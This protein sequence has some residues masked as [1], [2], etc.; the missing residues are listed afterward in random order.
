MAECSFSILLH[1]ASPKVSCCTSCGV[2]ATPIVGKVVPEIKFAVR[3]GSQGSYMEQ[4]M[5]KR[6]HQ[7]QH[8]FSRAFQTSSSPHVAQL[9][10]V[11]DG[12]S[13]EDE[14]VD[15][16][17][18]PA[19]SIYNVFYTNEDRGGAGLEPFT[20]GDALLDG[21]LLSKV[22]IEELQELTVAPAGGDQDAQENGR[23]SASLPRDKSKTKEEI[24]HIGKEELRGPSAGL[25]TMKDER[26]HSREGKKDILP[27]QSEGS[28]V[29][30]KA[31]TVARSKAR[32][33]KGKKKAPKTAQRQTTATP[34]VKMQVTSTVP[35]IKESLK[36]AWSST[37]HPI[38]HDL[39]SF[40]SSSDNH[41]KAGTRE[42]PVTREPDSGQS[43]PVAMLL[44]VTP[45]TTWI[46]GRSI[47]DDHSSDNQ[48]QATS[49][50]LHISRSDLP[51]PSTP[52]FATNLDHASTDD[53]GDETNSSLSPY[54]T[55]DEVE[56]AREWAA[57]DGSA[58]DEL[59]Q[60]LSSATARDSDTELEEDVGRDVWSRM[61][62][63]QLA[64]EF[65]EYQS[66]VMEEDDFD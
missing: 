10:P 28:T 9:L 64:Q 53:S 7:D 60:E 30:R 6:K 44:P 56:D 19:P 41:G 1:T 43:S 65:E 5:L 35:G 24:L 62:T 22:N 48:A 54:S 27:V 36:L 51:P 39:S 8:F 59:A 34:V 57:A 23:G 61:T 3:S 13:L 42:D 45:P 29:E 46:P 49:S 17:S 11:S 18:I 15:V 26:V 4:L 25:T 52:T 66:K 47:G 2:Q 38:P 55:K 32:G 58:L 20:S 40:F 50:L 12:S 16:P 37:Q 63:E 31:Q 14:A 33:A 21:C